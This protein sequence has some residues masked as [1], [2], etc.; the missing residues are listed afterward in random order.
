MAPAGAFALMRLSNP[1]VVDGKSQVTGVSDGDANALEPLRAGFKQMFDGLEQAGLP[2][3]KIALAWAFTTQSTVSTLRRRWPACRPASTA[4]RVCPTQPLY[5]FDIT[6]QVKGQMAALGLPSTSIGKVFQG[7]VVLP[8]LLT[9][10]S[11]TLNPTAPG[12][13]GLPSCWR[14]PPQPLRRMAIP[15]PSS[16]T[17][18]R[19][20][21]ST[22]IP[23]SRRPGRGWARD[24]R[25]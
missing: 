9:G 19:A 2:R 3:S 4:P 10:T 5:L 16:A 15:S 25:H 22:S 6:A 7:S 18:S 17:A 12:S 20:P 8:F 13:S 23:I 21:E 11:G 24:H 1:L 14:C